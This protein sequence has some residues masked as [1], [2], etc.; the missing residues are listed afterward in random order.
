MNLIWTGTL[1][2]LSILGLIRVKQAV[3]IYMVRKCHQY[4][5]W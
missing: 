5:L 3:M 4:Y 1:V 2:F